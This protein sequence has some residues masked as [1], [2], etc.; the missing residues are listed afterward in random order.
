MCEVLFSATEN[1]HE[2]LTSSI[3]SRLK[4]QGHSH[5][6]AQA[7][8]EERDAGSSEVWR[9]CVCQDSLD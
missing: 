4:A 9:A 8:L 1:V 5:M 7:L 2:N 6:N 3:Q